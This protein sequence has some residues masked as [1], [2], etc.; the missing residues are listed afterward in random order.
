MSIFTTNLKD[1]LVV[2]KDKGVAF[3][4]N[5]SLTQRLTGKF[6]TPAEIGKQLSSDICDLIPLHSNSLSIIDP[7]CGDGRLIEWLLIEL[8]TRKEYFPLENIEISLWDCDKYAVELAE[9][10][11]RSLNL[12]KNLKINSLATD[13]FFEVANFVGK[14]DICITNPPWEVLK[15]DS[16]ELS[17]LDDEQRAEY[18]QLLKNKSF[19]LESMFPQSRSLRRFS[20]WGTN[21]ARC[22]IET[23]LRLLSQNGIFGIVAPSTILGD[24]SSA[25]LRMWLFE[26]NKISHLR[27]YPAEARLFENV[28]QGVTC[29]IG[30]KDGETAHEITAK[31]HTSDL[32]NINDLCLQLSTLAS[33][34]YS[35]GFNANQ[36]IITVMEKISN[37]PK[38]SSFEGSSNGEIKLGRELDE[39][40]LIAKLS[41]S[42]PY[43]FLKGKYVARY[44]ILDHETVKIGTNMSIPKSAD[45]SRIGWRDVSRQSMPRRMQATIIPPGTVTGNSVN[46]ALIHGD[47]NDEVLRALLAIINSSI[48][49]MQS[50]LLI[51]TNHL[52]VGAV[53][54]FRVPNIKDRKVISCISNSLTQY[55]LT[56][57]LENLYAL[58]CEV[59]YCFGLKLDDLEIIFDFLRKK[60]AVTDQLY[61]ILKNT[62]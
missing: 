33:Q 36:N 37:F 62:N 23:A 30:L 44:K 14:Y 38:L 1:L 54:N 60:D 43:I 11:I 49:E 21:L 47:N 5:K 53:R 25:R 9:E 56:P 28:D 34:D 10:K 17:N 35:I 39:T 19:M 13:S 20:G 57:T 48:F 58:E 50:R 31:I 46:I 45:K 26:Q 2:A 29:L 3:N 8:A 32:K 12:F 52:S 59:A 40:G 27:Y 61:T 16:R 7:F 55:E 18:I 4:N 42:G 22:G 6:Y 41:A 24:Q 15:P 51:S